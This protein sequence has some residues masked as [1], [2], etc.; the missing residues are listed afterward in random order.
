MGEQL[1]DEQEPAGAAGY[2]D[3]A[4]GWGWTGGSRVKQSLGGLL[5]GAVSGRQEPTD[6]RQNALARLAAPAPG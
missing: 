5:A 1:A 3:A 4:G 6:A 2:A